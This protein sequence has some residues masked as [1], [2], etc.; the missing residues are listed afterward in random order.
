[1]KKILLNIVG[2]LLVLSIIACSLSGTVLV[3]SAKETETV[4]SLNAV[5]S[6][7]TGKNY[8]IVN[9]STG[10][11]LTTTIESGNHWYAGLGS[12]NHVLLGGAPA[13]DSAKW[14]F[15]TYNNGY[16]LAHPNGGYLSPNT[17]NVHI[18]SEYSWITPIYLDYNETEAAFQIYRTE[19]GSQYKL[20][21]CNDLQGNYIYAIG[22]NTSDFD[23]YSYWEIYEVVEGTNTPIDPEPEEPDTPVDPEPE[24]PTIEGLTAVTAIETGKEYVIVNKATGTVLTTTIESGNHWYAD[25]GSQNHVLLGGAP[26]ANSASWSF[27]T[28]NDGYALAHPDG[29]YLSPNTVNA[30]IV[31]EYTWTTPIYVDYNE[32]ESAFQIYRTENGSQYKLVA[33]NDLQGNYIYAIGCNNSEFDAYSYWEIYEIAETPEAPEVT[34]E[35]SPVTNIEIGRDYVIVNKSTG[36]VLTHTLEEGKYW[37]FNENKSYLRVEGEPSIDSDTFRFIPYDDG[38]AIEHPYGTGYVVPNTTNIGVAPFLEWITPVYAVYNETQAAFQLFRAPAENTMYKLVVCPNTNGEQICAIGTDST[39]WDDTS[40]WEIYEIV[41]EEVFV[42]SGTVVDLPRRLEQLAQQ[43]TYDILPVLTPAFEILTNASKLDKNGAKF[44][45]D[46]NQT[47]AAINFLREETD[48]RIEEILSS[49]N[50]NIPSGATVY[51][52]S[53]SGSDSNN[54][55]SPNT[56][57]ATLNKVNSITGSTGRDTY[58]LFERG[59]LW[60]GQL[61]AK[62]FV[63]YSAYGQGDKPKIYASPFDGASGAY[64]GKWTQHSTNIWKFQDNK[65]KTPNG[66]VIFDIGTLVFNNGED[67]A[68]KIS[69][70][71]LSTINVNSMLTADLQFYHDYKTGTVYLYSNTNP[72]IRFNSI[73]FNV[74]N[75]AVKAEST[76]ITID[77][78][79]IKYTGAHGVGTRSASNLTVTNCEFGWIGGSVHAIGSNQYTRFGNAVEIYGTCTNFTVS[80]NYI[81]QVYDAGITQQITLSEGSSGVQKNV[82]YSGNVIE[83]CYFSIEYWI[84]ST[85]ETNGYIDTFLIED[86]YMWYAGRGLCEQRSDLGNGSHINGWRS[87]DRNRAMNFAIRN[88]VM[89]DS[90]DIIANIYS[91]K[92]NPDGSDSMPIFNNNIILANHS[93][94]LG[95]I[96]QCEYANNTSWPRTVEFDENIFP[97]IDAALYGDVFGFISDS[98]YLNAKPI[99]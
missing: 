74:G 39:S 48:N 83:Y 66:T 17:V 55:T 87:Y 89:I 34:Y 81:Y 84:T 43:T 54:G 62:N 47:T 49:E 60:R 76:N 95:V 38:Y 4:L 59:G 96:E 27:T 46:T 79:C 37:H 12:Q 8:V 56:P 2:I 68:I 23:A 64:A 73:E 86:N 24:S 88:N 93:A 3:S 77:N 21:A 92:Y 5:T 70:Y 6:I 57:W 67:C 32:A 94:Q 63:T 19:N 42:E 28:Y 31:E 65:L 85:E 97:Y 80:D 33:C 29:G 91:L 41:G 18:T 99:F 10:T 26:S 75:H 98:L 20:V 15:I 78:L 36:T 25:L 71:G 51:Y 22:C 1:M 44:I 14:S 72:A 50:M 69:D 45:S 16:A 90:K 9:K 7:E 61:L 30:N 40:Y 82:L 11:V 13:V 58:V 35:L 53:N 52:V